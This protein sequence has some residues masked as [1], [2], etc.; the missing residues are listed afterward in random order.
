MIDYSNDSDEKNQSYIASDSPPAPFRD[1]VN[2]IADQFEVKHPGTVPLILARAAVGSDLIKMLTRNIKASN[3]KIRRITISTFLRTRS[4]F[5]TW[6]LNSVQ[7]RRIEGHVSKGD[8]CYYRLTLDT[9]LLCL[10]KVPCREELGRDFNHYFYA[11]SGIFHK[12]LG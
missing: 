8:R 1:F 10:A 12:H 9:G 2:F 5:Q 7:H 11:I 6:Y 4:E 3:G